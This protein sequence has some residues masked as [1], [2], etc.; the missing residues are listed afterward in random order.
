M[1]IYKVG[2]NVYSPPTRDYMFDVD[3]LQPTLLPPH[4]PMFRDVNTLGFTKV[5]R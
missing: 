3:F 5:L 1:G 2:A 4:T